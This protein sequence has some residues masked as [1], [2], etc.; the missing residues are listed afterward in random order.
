MSNYTQIGMK[1]ICKF[2]E[3]DWL[4]GL[5]Y[6]VLDV[7]KNKIPKSERKWMY[8]ERYFEVY[9]FPHNV[10]R[11]KEVYASERQMSMQLDQKSF[12]EMNEFLHQFDD[13]PVPKVAE[14]LL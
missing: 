8:K 5:A 2:D 9:A 10:K 14:Q 4:T 6:D 3:S 12:D 13:A 11:M 7:V 1:I